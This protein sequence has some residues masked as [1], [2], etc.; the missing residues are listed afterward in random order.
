MIISS[1][2]GKGN[3]DNYSTS[4]KIL[5]KCFGKM[6]GVIAHS[7]SASET[8][9]KLHKHAR[10]LN[11]FHAIDSHKIEIRS[12]YQLK[13]CI[14]LVYLG[15]KS[16][17]LILKILGEAKKRGLE[18][19]LALIGGGNKKWVHQYVE[20]QDLV[21]EVKYI[22]FLENEALDRALRNN[23]VFVLPSRYNTY[24]AV[25]QEAA[26]RGLALFISKN[27]GS[28]AIVVNN[29]NGW[30]FDPCDVDKSVDLL[31]TLK[32]EVTR[33]R[34]MIGASSTAVSY[35]ASQSSKRIAEYIRQ[36]VDRS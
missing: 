4:L 22:G 31:M 3:I 36:L 7:L 14:K 19:T 12:D 1:E 29:S 20:E 27:A 35:C 15:T 13:K 28:S 34:M 16:I 9:F 26:S 30:E 6:D 33:K 23:E 32:D 2:L 18:F 24:G 21:N 11:A 10:V 25:T 8:D 5:R 17:D